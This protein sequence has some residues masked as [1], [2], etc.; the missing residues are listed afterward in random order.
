MYNA[1]LDLGARN[2]RLPRVG[3]PR[4]PIDAGHKAIFHPTLLEIRQDREPELGAFRLPDPEAS[5]CLVP[6][7][8]DAQRHIDRC[9]FDGSVMPRFHQKT[10]EIENRIHRFQ[11]TPL[12]KTHLL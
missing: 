11:R 3:Q 2:D 1:Q 7:E 12:P 8:G 9:G 10:I 4:Q 5:E 6:R